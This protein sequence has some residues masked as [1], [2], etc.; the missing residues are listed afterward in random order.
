MYSTVTYTERLCLQLSDKDFYAKADYTF[1]GVQIM[2]TTDLRNHDN[3]PFIVIFK[4]K[5][6]NPG[7]H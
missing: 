2:S 4:T 3:K 1:L 6:R 5:E 7:S